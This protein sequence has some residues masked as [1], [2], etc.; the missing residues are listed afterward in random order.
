MTTSTVKDIEQEIAGIHDVPTLL[1]MSQE[2]DAG[3]HRRGVLN[4][5]QSRIG[6]VVMESQQDIAPAPANDP[7]EMR[8][9]GIPSSL[10]SSISMLSGIQDELVETVEDLF[11]VEANRAL[12]DEG[13]TPVTGGSV[14]HRSTPIVTLYLPTDQG[15]S[16]RQVPATNV[17]MLL[18]SGWL[19]RCPDCHR[20][21]C[22]LNGDLN[23][24]PAVPKRQFA[25]CPV[26]RHKRIYDP[27]PP[28]GVTVVLDAAA[29]ENEIVL[30]TYSNLP[31]EAR[32]RARLEQH[33]F[34]YHPEE[35]SALGLR[36]QS[37]RDRL[38]G[39]PQLGAEV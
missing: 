20:P 25:W 19:D 3:P 13:D 14:T 5:L 17:L 12:R 37:P 22:R 28:K 2:E 21:D 1:R 7:A 23:D 8:F 26:G 29:D 6:Q 27:T 18:R 31:P 32:I 30:D 38:A 39:A 35:A 9:A 33:L 15:Y 11:A 34:A 24:C 36:P 4:A 16:P 10:P